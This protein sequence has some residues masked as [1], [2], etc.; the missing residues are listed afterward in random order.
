[1][2]R[3][4]F[5]FIA[6]SIASV[7]QAQSISS[8]EVPQAVMSRLNGL[9]P[10]AS[11]FKWE[12][13]DGMYIASFKNLKSETS[14]L[15]SFDGTVIR[16]ESI[17]Q[18]KVVPTDAQV[19]IADITKSKKNHEVNKIVDIYGAVTYKVELDDKAYIFDKNGRLLKPKE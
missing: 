16:T 19:S 4:L 9:Y 18:L 12:M 8:T 2:S 7:S 6:F 5:L 13:E 11:T 17:I 15:L 14:I 1:M 3:L 10:D